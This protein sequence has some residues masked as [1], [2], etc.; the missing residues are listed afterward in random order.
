[1]RASKGSALPPLTGLVAVVLLSA[2]LLVGS[3]APDAGDGGRKIL[4]F[5]AANDS[6]QTAGAILL[7]YGSLFLVLFAAAL[8]SG[9][10]RGQ[11]DVEGPATLAFGGGL[12]MA[13]GTLILAGATLALSQDS[14]ALAPGAA[15]AVNLLSDRVWILPFLVGQSVLM[16]AAGAAILRGGALPSWLGWVAVILGAASATPASLLAFTAALLW[17]VVV[18]IMLSQRASAAADDPIDDR[19]PAA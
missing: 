19:R 14:E 12:V 4:D 10:R 18:A 16:L 1:M 6:E 5:Y 3:G 7:T 2:G 15:Q 11:D 8:R 9:L 13:A 17:I